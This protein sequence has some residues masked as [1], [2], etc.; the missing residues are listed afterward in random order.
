MNSFSKYYQI[1]GLKDN[2]TE[3]EIK[4]AYR[5]LA[6]KYHPD[7]YVNEPEQKK[8]AAEKFKE[9][10]HG[11]EVIISRGKNTES[12]NYQPNSTKI[13]VKKNDPKIYFYL[14]NLALE[15]E[16]FA[17]AV[18]YFSLAISKNPQYREAYICRAIAYEK[19]GF[20]IRA[21]NDWRKA[22]T[23]KLEEDFAKKLKRKKQ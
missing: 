19:Q 6:K 2:A 10:A 11:Y 9:I 17:Q 12:E 14:G 5:T 3:Q 23:L 13:K 4:Q 7:N 15:D 16:D 18:E 1:L 22:K 20:Q 8:I 21:E